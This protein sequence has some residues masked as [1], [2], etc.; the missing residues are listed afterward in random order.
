M[1]KKAEEKTGLTESNINELAQ[2]FKEAPV[3][4]FA[5]SRT[6]HEDTENYTI[7][8]L[9]NGKYE[10]VMKYKQVS[11]IPALTDEEVFKL[12][13]VMN[14]PE[15]TIVTPMKRAIDKVITIQNFHTSPYESFDEE[16]GENSNGVTTIIEDVEGSYY[17]TS[18]KSVYY[19]LMNAYKVFADKMTKQHLKVKVV[20]KQAEKGEQI[21][22]AVLELV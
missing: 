14:D 22:L 19:S 7:Y 20:A 6:I 11:L 9:P 2:Q 17:G 21:N 1:P 8:L 18:S 12:Y 5:G 4:T 10:K 16:T 13:Q 3:T 15:N